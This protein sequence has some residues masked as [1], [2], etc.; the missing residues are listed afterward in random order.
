MTNAELLDL[1]A[2]QDWARERILP[3]LEPLTAEEWRR[4]LGGSFVH[5]HA[6]ILHILGAQE[7]WAARLQGGPARGFPAP[8]EVPNLAAIIPR[9]RADCGALRSW[10]AAQPADAADRIVRYTRQGQVVETPVVAVMLQLSHHHAY[11]LGQVVHMLRQLGR[12]PAD[13]G[14]ISYQRQRAAAS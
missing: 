13:T 6:T 8:D 11:H 9:W 1:I 7:I 4:P 2:F 14:Y 5:L 10:L 12:A 3:A